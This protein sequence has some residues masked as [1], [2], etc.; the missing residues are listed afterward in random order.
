[1]LSVGCCG[2]CECVSQTA[3][4][5]GLLHKFYTLNMCLY[6]T[7]L[8]SF[9]YFYTSILLCKKKKKRKRKKKRSCKH[10]FLAKP[11]KSNFG[12]FHVYTTQNEYIVLKGLWKLND[13]Y[14][15]KILL[16]PDIKS[17]SHK[18]TWLDKVWNGFCCFLCSWKVKVFGNGFHQDSRVFS[19]EQGQS[20]IL[21]A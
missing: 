10:C 19:G 18:T 15:Y 17:K 6:F 12:N 16:I 5:K 14:A 9:I 2:V 1:M 7:A 20:D 13:M 8:L 11:C 3:G 4:R 21:K